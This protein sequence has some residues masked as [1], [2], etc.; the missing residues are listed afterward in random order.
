MRAPTLDAHA[1]REIEWECQKLILEFYGLLDDKRYDD[2]A[3]LFA[4]DGVWVRLGQ[5][6]VGP[7]GIKHA[8][9]ER[10][11]WLTMHLVS[12]LRIKVIDTSH[13]ETIQYVTLYRQEGIDPTAGPPPVV[14]PLGLLR[15]TDKLVRVGGVWK[16]QR[17][18]SRAVM[19]NRERVT[20]YDKP[21]AKN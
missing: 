5:E 14:L 8:M 1:T 21:P 11:S 6:L 3:D 19:V 12:N 15:H 9:A 13:A 10:E 17:K 4:E 20:H 7:S 18:A 16:F 2:L